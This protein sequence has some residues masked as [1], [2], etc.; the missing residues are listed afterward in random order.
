MSSGEV[1]VSRVGGSRA[2]VQGGL[3]HRDRQETRNRS[4]RSLNGGSLFWPHSSRGAVQPVR[5][6]DSD[7]QETVDPS[8]NVRSARVSRARQTTFTSSCRRTNAQMRVLR[9][10]VT[11]QF[12]LSTSMT[13]FCDFST[14]PQSKHLDNRCK[15]EKRVTKDFCVLV[16]F[17][18]PLPLT[19]KHK[20]TQQYTAFFGNL[21][22]VGS[23]VDHDPCQLCSWF[24]V[25]FLANGAPSSQSELTWL[26]RLEVMA[27]VW[28][29]PQRLYFPTPATPNTDE[30]FR[31]YSVQ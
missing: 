24:R 2:G 21:F 10:G 31:L 8:T 18:P 7:A 16:R 25:N 9:C 1:W 20:M 4:W 19:H 6:N 14:A 30:R 29:K 23:L 27:V 17:S 28:L 5:A 26:V 15:G 13:R 3:R 22:F 12:N 11:C